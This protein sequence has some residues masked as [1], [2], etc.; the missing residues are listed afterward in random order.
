MDT[1]V[2]SKTWTV[3]NWVLNKGKHPKCSHSRSTP[4]LYF[5]VTTCFQLVQRTWESF[6][7]WQCWCG[8]YLVKFHLPVT[9]IP[10][11]EGASSLA[12]RV[13]FSID[14]Y[15]IVNLTMRSSSP[16]LHII[17]IFLQTTRIKCPDDYTLCI[18]ICQYF[19][20]ELEGGRM[21]TF[22]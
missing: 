2:T 7:C 15:G 17:L 20:F 10:N 5:E 14:A 8:V 22:I 1:P 6:S 3:L 11:L 13:Q 18:G 9:F 12:L 4:S 21:Q 16:K 19:E